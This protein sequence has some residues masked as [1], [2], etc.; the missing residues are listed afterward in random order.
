MAEALAFNLTEG[1]E[2]QRK[3][4]MT[5]VN[6]GT[7]AAK[8]WQLVGSGVEDSAIEYNVDKTKVTDILG[9]TKAKVNKMEP[10]QSFTPYTVT[11]GDALQLQLYNHYRNDRRAEL[12]AYE[13]LVVHGYV[14]TA[15]TAM[16]SELHSNCTLSVDSIGGSSYVDMPLTI[17]FSN[18]K[19]LGTTSVSAGTFTF[20]PAT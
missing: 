18:D 17:D 15:D 14:G 7:S 2:A 13:V 19:T 3:L 16:E 20:T 12:S 11:G 1:I 9:I 4:L 5:L 6:V 8:V 10:T